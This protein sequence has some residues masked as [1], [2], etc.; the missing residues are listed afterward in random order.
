L[1]LCKNAR[2]LFLWGR[3]SRF[4][5]GEEFFGK[6]GFLIKKERN[7]AV[8]GIKKTVIF[9]AMDGKMPFS[10]DLGSW[11]RKRERSFYARKRGTIIPSRKLLVRK[12]QQSLT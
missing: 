12:Q 5:L 3:K 6:A 2:W 11:K 1:N 10:G 9:T 8:S 4:S 7:S